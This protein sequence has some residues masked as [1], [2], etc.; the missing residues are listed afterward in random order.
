MQTGKLVKMDKREKFRKLFLLQEDFINYFS[1]SDVLEILFDV[2]TE[3]EI[4]YLNEQ[5]TVFVRTC[6]PASKTI[7]KGLN[8]Y[9]G[10]EYLTLITVDQDYYKKLL[11]EEYVGLFLHEIGHFLNNESKYTNYLDGEYIADAYANT[12]GFGRYIINSLEKAIKYNWTNFI[13][14]ECELRI[15]ALRNNPMKTYGIDEL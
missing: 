13:K 2:L 8:A 5:N 7:L 10:K 4:D 12:K 6:S 11:P 9:E 3:E 14:V 1:T 15:S